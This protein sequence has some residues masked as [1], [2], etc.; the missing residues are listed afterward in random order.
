[1]HAVLVLPLSDA[2][3]TTTSGGGMIDWVPDHATAETIDFF[4]RKLPQQRREHFSALAKS[5]CGAHARSVVI[6][7]TEMSVGSLP[8]AETAFHQMKSRV[9]VKLGDHHHSAIV[10]HVQD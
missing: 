9:G 7:F 1:M 5:A 3:L 8:S 10:K 2:A 6:C 4:G